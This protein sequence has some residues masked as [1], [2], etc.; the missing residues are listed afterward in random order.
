MNGAPG[1]A[2]NV[3]ITMCIIFFGLCKARESQDLAAIISAYLWACR[4]TEEGKAHFQGAD[5]TLY[6]LN[7]PSNG[8]THN[9]AHGT[10]G[11]STHIVFRFMPLDKPNSNDSS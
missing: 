6:L 7:H 9:T 2:R 4:K 8:D 3:A 11:Y 5:D 1:K 10:R